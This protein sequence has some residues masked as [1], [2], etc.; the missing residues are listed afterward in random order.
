MILILNL[1]AFAVSAFALIL[2]VVVNRRLVKRNK[3]L[4]DYNNFLI[5]KI[6]QQ[7]AEF[8]ILRE[9]EPLQYQIRYISETNVG[10]V[11]IWKK[12]NYIMR[13]VLIKL[14]TDPDQD[15]N[16]RCAEELLDMLNAR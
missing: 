9:I 11:A 16:R 12:D 4:T 8:D 14:F 5:M 10:V 13:V 7:C 2:A 3:E 1:I 15:Y 6:D